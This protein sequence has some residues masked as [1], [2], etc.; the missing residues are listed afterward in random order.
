MIVT[1]IGAG[2]IGANWAAAFLAGGHSV[3]LYDND[4]D[5]L[6]AG[7]ART[8]AAIDLL[9]SLGL[10]SGDGDVRSKLSTSTNLEEALSKADYVQE[11]ISE[12]VDAKRSLFEAIDAVAGP[13]LIVGSS[14]S[15]IPGTYFMGG[16]GISDRALVVHPT[17]PPYVI[18][19]VE[20]CRT[21]W[22]SNATV[23]SVRE[24]LTAIGRVCVDVRRELPGYVL[25]R[26]QAAVVGEALH[27]VGEGY[28]SAAD[29]DNV[30]AMGLAPRWA[31]GGPFLTGH[32]NA[33]GGYA[34][35]MTRY[36]AVYRTMIADLNVDYKW[37]DALL[38]EID[39]SVRTAYGNR[40]VEVLQ[41]ARDAALLQLERTLT[42]L[43]ALPERGAA[44]LALHQSP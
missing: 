22:T 5:R 3:I 4:V 33:S 6:K 11:S 23:E 43:R 21:P 30:M 17:N 12:D 16:L 19:L 34:D 44:N 27:L 15:A 13:N 37:S 41:S 20:L 28:V 25:N 10:A 31:L 38:H 26:L 29:L 8:L 36:G 7:V 39:A 24:L 35:Y 2:M 40:S 14:T 32:L 9:K 42:K 1:S 18:P